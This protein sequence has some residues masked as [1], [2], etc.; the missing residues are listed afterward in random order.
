VIEG[1]ESLYV[2]EAEA[3]LGLGAEWWRPRNLSVSTGG[4]T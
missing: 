4:R 1:P 3:A 2:A